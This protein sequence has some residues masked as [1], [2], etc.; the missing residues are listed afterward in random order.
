MAKLTCTLIHLPFITQGAKV[1]NDWPLPRK[2]NA[3][4]WAVC[5]NS[6]LFMETVIESN[7]EYKDNLVRVLIE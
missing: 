6:K 3:I 2:R 4:L 7:N 1:I 5:F